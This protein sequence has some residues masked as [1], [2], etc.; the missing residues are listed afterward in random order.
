MRVILK[1]LLEDGARPL[2]QATRLVPDRPHGSDVAISSDQVTTA[3]GLGDP[4]STSCTCVSPRGVAK[5]IGTSCPVHPWPPFPPHPW[6]HDGLVRGLSV[7]LHVRHPDVSD[8]VSPRRCFGIK[9]KQR[10]SC[11]KCANP[12]ELWHKL[13]STPKSGTAADKAVWVE[14]KIRKTRTSHPPP[15]VLSSRVGPSHKS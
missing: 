4:V 7:A 6:G 1:Q 3:S 15:C 2:P 12:Q 8:V 14:W 10:L 11:G 9:A 13:P 5:S